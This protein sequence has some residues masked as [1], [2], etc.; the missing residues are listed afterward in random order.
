MELSV[1]AT[2]ENGI[3][4][5]LVPLDLPE[6]ATVQLVVQSATRV[7]PPTTQD[8]LADVLGICDGPAD[9]AQN[10]DRY[11]YAERKDQ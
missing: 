6:G 2:F 3:L 8:P 7:A 5:P 10:H 4:R 9:G 11:I 1:T